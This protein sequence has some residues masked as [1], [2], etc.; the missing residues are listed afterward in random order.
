MVVKRSKG[1]SSAQPADDDWL[2]NL[3]PAGPGAPL[4]AAAQH[5]ASGG[6]GE[7]SRWHLLVVD[8]PDTG[9]Q[10]PLDA[11]AR[12]GRSSDNDV[13]LADPQASRQHAVIQ[14]IAGS[15]IINDL[16]SSN[17][18][19]VAGS[20]IAEPSRLREGDTI[21]IGNTTL[22]LVTSAA[23]PEPRRVPT[24][25]PAPAAAPAAAAA[26]GGANF[27]PNCGHSLM[28]GARF[29]AICGASL[30]GAAVA[31]PFAYQPTPAVASAPSS[32]SVVG[33]LS[34]VERRKGLLGSEAFNLVLTAD[35]LVFAKV[36]SE[37]LKEAIDEAR[38]GAK[39]QGKGFFGQWGAQLGASGSIAERY[40]QMPV[41][42][43]LRENPDNFQLPLGQIQK[44]QVKHGQFDE[45]Q[46]N[47]DYVVI[48]AGGKMRFNLKG[49]SAG[50]AKKALREVLGER[51]R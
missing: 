29:C 43:I 40:Y 2:D 9:K 45:Q 5:G 11:Q 21:R 50:Q 8:G 36:T 13:H 39:A 51:V 30:D 15:W 32:E 26:G 37:M 3:P 1:R 44:V 49:V 38:R 20:R 42:A 4:P 47:P 23:A 19:F 7:Q 41:D 16:G 28:A 17:G 18:T 12:L 33:V 27:C 25:R 48:H 46:T 10:F 34:F 14:R 35:R 24:S 22:K 31:T 6:H